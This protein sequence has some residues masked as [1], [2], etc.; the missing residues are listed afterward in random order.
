LENLPWVLHPLLDEGSDQATD[1][2]PTKVPLVH[3]L[4]HGLS[5]WQRN[6]LNLK[7]PNGRTVH[8]G[9]YR[10]PWIWNECGYNELLNFLEFRKTSAGDPN[11]F[12]EFGFRSCS[13]DQFGFRFGSFRIRIQSRKGS[14]SDPSQN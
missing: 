9:S 6:T 13:S 11:D 14:D 2:L 3:A 4:V 7:L 1:Q 12:F 5:L 10:D 8:P